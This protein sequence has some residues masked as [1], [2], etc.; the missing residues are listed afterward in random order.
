MCIPGVSWADVFSS[1]YKFVRAV[2]S[3]DSPVLS[4]FQYQGQSREKASAEF[5]CCCF[6]NN[7]S[8]EEK[9]HWGA[10]RGFTWV[11]CSRI[12]GQT[13]RHIRALSPDHESPLSDW[14][15]KLCVSLHQTLFLLEVLSL[16]LFPMDF[17]CETNTL[18]SSVQTHSCVKESWFLH[19]VIVRVGFQTPRHL[20][21]CPWDPWQVK[22]C[23]MWL[24]Q[25]NHKIQA[26]ALWTQ[27]MLE[28]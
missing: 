7:M 11:V 9:K 1:T 27:R 19:P 21:G 12:S 28:L 25:T 6:L 22:P 2:L 17:R 8:L 16:W 14:C 20:A 15:P 13:Q 23:W 24:P 10:L 5:H 4:L 26:R 3:A 18:L